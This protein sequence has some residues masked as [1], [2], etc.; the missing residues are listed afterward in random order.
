[1]QH[2][3]DLNKISP[4]FGYEPYP[5]YGPDW[6]AKRMRKLARKAEGPEGKLITVLP[7]TALVHTDP[8]D[9]GRY[10]R[11]QDPN[12][13]A[14][15]WKRMSTSLGWD[16]QG[17]SDATGHSYHGLMWYRINA[18]AP[19][20]AAGKSV[21]LYAPAVVNEAWVWVNGQYAG[22][23]AYKL[24]WFRPQALELDIT[25][26]VK[27]GAKNLITFRVLNNIDVFGASGIYERMFIYSKTGD[28]PKEDAKEDE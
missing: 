3:K 27:P 16:T 8:A 15:S 7:E 2:H 12:F 6:E 28:A 19:K 23:R 20:A 1:V 4:F 5:A 13:D 18:E 9:D 24:P 10:E 11:W 22:H 14:S 17:F 21:W 26:F 25:P